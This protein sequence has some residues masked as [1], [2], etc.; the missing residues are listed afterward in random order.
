MGTRTMRCGL[1]LLAI[2]ALAAV[3]AWP[4][5]AARYKLGRTPSADE[6]QAWDISVGI[7]GKELPPGSGTA[8]DGAPLYA[9]QCVACHGMTG[10]DTKGAPR[11]F[12]GQGTLNTPKPVKT[13]GSFWPY[14][15]TVW[16]YIHRAMPIT[17]PGSLS[18]DQSY[19]L[20]A[21]ILFRNGIIKEDETMDQK[22]LPKVQ[23]TNR[24]GFS[25]AIPEIFLKHC[26]M[27]T[28]P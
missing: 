2:L 18:V 8:K 22:S 9:K 14:A 19:A 12:G 24:D 6:V 10:E 3:S 26:R 15:T 28:C 4:Q 16:D 25:P 11:L 1:S 23:M 7:D 27:G 20:T 17:K 13:V 5:Q 21:Y